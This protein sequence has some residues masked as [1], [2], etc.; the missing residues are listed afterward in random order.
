MKVS[1]V[2]YNAGNIFS[3]INAVRHMGI[4]PLWTDDPE[5]LM[6]S[7]R[8]IFPGQG[9]ASNAMNY[10]RQRGLDR[11]IADLRQPVL[12]IC[13]GQQL[14]CSHSEEGDTDCI[15]IFPIQ[16]KRF[17]PNVHE[18]KVPCMGWNSLNLQPRNMEAVT[19][20][21]EGVSPLF[22]G[23]QKEDFVYFVHSYYCELCDN[24]IATA[25]YIHP[26]S[27]ALQKDNFYATQFHPEKSGR[28]GRQ[29]LKNFIEI[30]G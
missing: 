23:L 5:E 15:G 2:K 30:N 12:G 16:V 11:L 1:I 27:A 14:L 8:V 22:K 7:D 4:E 18:E 29:I 3:V 20:T 10:L 25:D 6:S 9:E 24:T 19:H 26:Y 13:I 28:V 21:A 17:Q